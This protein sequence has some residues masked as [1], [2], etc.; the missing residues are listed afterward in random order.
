[1]THAATS[2]APAA[3][4]PTAAPP[5][6]D[7]VRSMLI[8]AIDLQNAGD[9][10]QAEALLRDYLR[11]VP[12]D[13]VAWYSLGVILI[14]RGLRADHEAALHVTA[15]GLAAAPS[16]AML[17][18]LHGSVLQTL[19][20]FDAALASWDRA[21]ELKPDYAEILLNSGALL[22]KML[23][24]GPALE[25]FERLLALQPDHKAA[26]SNSA[27]LLSEFKR[28]DASIARFE[29]LLALDPKWDYGPGLLLYE[30]LHVCDWT[31][32]A[33]LARRIADG[34]AEGRRVCKSLAL[35]AVSDDPVA[36]Q[37]AARLFTAHHFPPARERL[38]KGE[39]YRH[40]RIRVAYLSAD[41]REHPVGHLLAGVIEHHDRRR[42][43]TYGISI[44][45]DDGSPQRDRL[46]GAFEHF[47]DV[48]GWGTA[49]VAQWIREHEIDIAIDLG[50][51]TSDARSD[52]LAMK[53]APVQVN[54]LG[55]PG[56]MGV[57]TMDVIL[58]DRHVIPPG[59]EHFY[60]EEVVRLPHA[61]LPTDASLAIA[62][63]T[64]TRAECA[65]PDEGFVFC[66][67]NHDYKI[68]PDVFALWL[69]L[70]QQV[71]H[72]VL[73]LMSRN[74]QSQANLRAAAAAGGVDPARLV[75]A[76]RV[77]KVEDHLLRYRVADLF[78]DT[79]P[80]NAHTTAADALMAGLPVLTRRGRSFPS[81]VAA[82]LVTVAGVPELATDS[83]GDYEQLALDL[84]RDPQR[85]AT[86]RARVATART[87]SPLFDTA[88]FTRDLEAAWFALWRRTQLGDVGDA[89][90]PGV[91]Y[92]RRADRPSTRSHREDAADPLI[93]SEP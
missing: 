6:V 40:E 25:R 34:L 89:L 39:I 24:H 84:A 28:S 91:A 66:C 79:F 1:M 58:A 78:L 51:Y 82:G 4:A 44:G 3:P 2:T 11:Q 54:W 63:R 23:R 15:Q 59:H 93:V 68:A 69:R 36:H 18:G 35:M 80:Y 61:Y 16:F 71:P 76:G 85:L 30:R 55:Y 52:I 56:T 83:A 49:Q 14:R 60:D 32:H 53:P 90:G 72:S 41:L 92:A 21:L 31:G 65:L 13:P 75:F 73:W 57:S 87:G 19:G 33:E 50:G 77:P 88:G 29:R 67:F 45:I 62:E 26:L 64:P 47:V 37:Q 43:E 7:T 46:K 38:W 42:F 17:W 48:R 9:E 5:A 10:V 70:L 20:H 8:R 86:L 81:R 74:A 22:R 27:I 12:G